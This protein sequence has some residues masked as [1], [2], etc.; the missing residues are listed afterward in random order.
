MWL[1]IAQKQAFFQ[2]LKLWFCV[3]AAQFV[4]FALT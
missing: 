4:V 3:V 2:G 1:N